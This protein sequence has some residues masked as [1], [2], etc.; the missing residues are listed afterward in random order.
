MKRKH[1][2]CVVL[3]LALSLALFSACRSSDSGEPS[4]PPAYS[5]PYLDSLPV[6][7][8]WGGYEWVVLK[9]E[10]TRWLCITKE[11]I[12]SRKFHE[13]ETPV[14]WEECDL[15][16]YLNG[17]FFEDTFGTVVGNE[18]PAQI[19]LTDNTNESVAF[20]NGSTGNG[21]APTRDYVFLLSYEE[22]EAYFPDDAARVAAYHVGK[23]EVSAAPIRYA[24]HWWLRSPGDYLNDFANVDGIGQVCY[25]QSNIHT[26][27]LGLRPAIWV[28]VAPE[29]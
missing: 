16:A 14:S 11:I 21:S 20:P 22:A 24:Q 18:T 29:E 28:W 9:K 13:V 8:N 10:E 17:E 23:D 27:G 6:A 26:E 19:I 15:R 12:E 1:I 2:V 7:G 4:S 3:L 5:N 25:S